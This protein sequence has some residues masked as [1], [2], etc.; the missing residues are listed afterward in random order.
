MH[1]PPTL[2]PPL[3]PIERY[4]TDDLPPD[5]RYQAWL[6]RGWFRVAPIFRTVPAEPFNTT[7]ESAAAG[8]L[9][10]MYT[11][12]TAMSWER[13]VDDIRDSDFQPF[14]VNMM[15]QGTAQGDMDGRPFFEPAG[16]LSFP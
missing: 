12:I 3:I 1:T 8:R 9:L 13:R 15:V 2:S 11:E 14:S 10:V 5:E 16:H 4:S 7:I 6:D